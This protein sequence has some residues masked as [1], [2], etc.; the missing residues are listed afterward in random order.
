MKIGSQAGSLV[1]RNALT[2]A[3]G[4]AL[5]KVKLY[6]PQVPKQQAEELEIAQKKLEMQIKIIT[7]ALDLIERL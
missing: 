7:P 2:I 4:Y 5:T 1:V 6:L 3:G